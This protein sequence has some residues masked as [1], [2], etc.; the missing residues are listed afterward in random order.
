M[1]KDLLLS[2]MIFNDKMVAKEQEQLFRPSL[3]AH[4]LCAH[5]LGGLLPSEL[6]T[7]LVWSRR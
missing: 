2:M 5:A 4:L 7:K 1:E 6:G 3:V